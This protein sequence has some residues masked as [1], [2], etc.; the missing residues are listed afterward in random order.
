MRG[1]FD[2]IVRLLG[3]EALLDRFPLTLSGGEKQRVAIGRALLTAPEIL[4]M[5]EPLAALD[6]P[7]KRELMPYLERLAQEVSI[8]ILYVTHSLDEILRLAEKVLVLDAGKVLAMGD[9]ETSGRATLCAR[10]CRR[11]NKA[12][13]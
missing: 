9:L 4:L 11:K 3:I 13:C 6:I 7:R 8:P 10:G 1:Q 5:D 2:S 12:V